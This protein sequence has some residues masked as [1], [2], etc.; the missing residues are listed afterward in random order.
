MQVYI[1]RD[2]SLSNSSTPNFSLIDQSS[3]SSFSSWEQLK[4]WP[5]FGALGSCLVAS[6]G[7]S[8]DRFFP[9][10]C[11]VK[12]GPSGKISGRL[13]HVNVHGGNLSQ[14]TM[15]NNSCG[16]RGIFAQNPWHLSPL[17]INILCDMGD[18]GMASATQDSLG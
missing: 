13:D 14:N 15:A 6:I 18:G 3:I 11:A 12:G 17:P 2:V 10:G 16:I 7:Q 8:S 4:S 1:A 9:G 5:R